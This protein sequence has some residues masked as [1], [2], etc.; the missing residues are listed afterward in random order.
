MYIKDVPILGDRNMV[1]KGGEKVLKCKE[2]TPKYSDYG[3]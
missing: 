3:M 2:L 1:K